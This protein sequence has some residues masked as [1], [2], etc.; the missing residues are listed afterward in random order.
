MKKIVICLVTL[1]LLATT[2]AHA[3]DAM[4]YFNLGLR[5]S[6]ENQR[7]EYF[8][9]ALQ[10]NPGLA[11]AYQKRGMLYY[12][13][14]KYDNVIQDFKNYTKLVPEEADGYRMLG[15]GYLYKGLHGEAIDNFTRAIKID[16]NLTSAFCYRAKAF[17]LSGKNEEAILDSTR[18]IQLGGDPR[19]LASAYATRAQAYYEIGRDKLGDAD[20]S[21]SFEVDPT[22]LFAEACLYR[23]AVARTSLE[24]IRKVGFLGLIGI[25]V[26]LI[27]RIKLWS[28]QKDE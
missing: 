1:F 6:M 5:S 11:A 20:R 8:S 19:D 15:M 23:P 18:A 26:V 24:D 14:E 25:A 16:P 17:R 13:Q 3:E 27:L 22:N 9:K 10:L 7:I 2:Q 12:F 4:E 21:K 28:P